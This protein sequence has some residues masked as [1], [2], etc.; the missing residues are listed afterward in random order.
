MLSDQTGRLST[1]K[2]NMDSQYP[3]RLMQ[4]MALGFELS[5]TES[6]EF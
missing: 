4:S 2:K 3:H 5:P 6:I 1:G